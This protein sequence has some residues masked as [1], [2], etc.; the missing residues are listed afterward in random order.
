MSSALPCVR[1][2][3]DLSERDESDIAAALQFV[4]KDALPRIA[5]MAQ[6][7]AVVLED[8]LVLFDRAR[9]I[10]VELVQREI[11]EVLSHAV[12]YAPDGY[13]LA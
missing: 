2:T 5:R 4:K 11:R 8:C 7:K 13:V 9:K 12:D 10:Y 1:A 3:L 6:P